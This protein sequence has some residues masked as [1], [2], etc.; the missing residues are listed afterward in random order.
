MISLKGIFRI[1]GSKAKMN[2]LI[3][4]INSG[5]LDLVDFNDYD[6]H[7]LASVLK[8]YLRDLPDSIMCNE[9]YDD[10]LNAVQ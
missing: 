8:Q 9:F 7:C 4:S 6:V 2:R 5:Y 1:A 3:Y 10:W